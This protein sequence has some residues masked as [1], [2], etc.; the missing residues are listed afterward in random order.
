MDAIYLSARGDVLRL[1]ARGC[2]YSRVG[3]RTGMSLKLHPIYMGFRSG[4][5]QPIM[6]ARFPGAQDSRKAMDPTIRLTP[7]ERDVLR[8]LARGGTYSQVGDRLGISLHTV[9]THVKNVY[10]K[11]KVHSA[12][13]A[14]WRAMELQLLGEPRTGGLRARGRLS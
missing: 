5:L 1:L 7:R 9:T 14:I 8:L 12:R 11:L 4:R 6:R 2:T 3:D 13:A 10:R